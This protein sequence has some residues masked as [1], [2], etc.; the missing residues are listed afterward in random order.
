MRR[1]PGICRE[2]RKTGANAPRTGW[3]MNLRRVAFLVDVLLLLSLAALAGLALVLTFVL[4]P[5]AGSGGEA[6]LTWL[7]LPR[8][9]WEMVQF[10]GLL[11]V[12][13]LAVTHL[14]LHCTQDVKPSEEA[15]PQARTGKILAPLGAAGLLLCLPLL[16]GLGMKEGATVAGPAAGPP[17]VQP[18]GSSPA[19][20]PEARAAV[21][22]VQPSPRQ[23]E[24]KTAAVTKAR[25][26]KIPRL[27]AA[28]RHPARYPTRAARSPR[29]CPPGIRGYLLT[30]ARR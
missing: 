28:Y 25:P 13:S 5:A 6:T 9:H 18:A 1:R 15:A 8:H 14:V 11:F 20:I 16:A 4:I 19:R 23:A 10:S 30:A 21:P 7:G 27:R 22:A 2:P 3:S 26:R 29:H 17:A 12:L 24:R